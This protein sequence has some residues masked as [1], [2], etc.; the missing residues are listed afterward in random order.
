MIAARNKMPDNRKDNDHFS[1]LS[2]SIL[3]VREALIQASEAEQA[4]SAQREIREKWRFRVE[5]GTL[6]ALVV[7]ALVAFGGI[8]ITH[9]DTLKALREVHVTADQQH[10]DTLAAIAKAQQ[11]IEQLKT[12]ADIMHEQ[13]VASSGFPAASGHRQVGICRLTE[14]AMG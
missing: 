5:L 6:A 1:A 3:S 11:N 13:L 8:V 10:A 14:S 2:S 9:R 4:H 12:Q 7:A